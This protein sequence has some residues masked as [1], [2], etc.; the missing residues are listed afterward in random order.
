[1]FHPTN[2]FKRDFEQVA[3]KLLLR[4]LSTRREIGENYKIRRRTLIPNVMFSVAA[5]PP[6]TPTGNAERRGAREKAETG[7]QWTQTTQGS[8]KSR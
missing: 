4:I 2:A 5:A 8:E 3:I 7:D 1:M 6:A